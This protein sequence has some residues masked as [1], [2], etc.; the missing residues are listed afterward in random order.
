M[1]NPELTPLDQYTFARLDEILSDIQ[2]NP[3]ESPILFSLGEPQKPTPTILADT[4]EAHKT[5]WNRYPSPRGDS[6][7]REAAVNWLYRRYSLPNGFV[8]PERHVIPVPGTRQPLCQIGFICTPPE[9]NRK[10]PAILMPNPFYHVY[11]GAALVGRGEPIY[12]S[13]EHESD[14]LPVLGEISEEILTRTSIMF[15]CTPT[16]PQGTVATTKYLK[17]AIALAREYDFVLAV[18]ECYSEIYRDSPPPGG[19]EACSELGL[20]MENVVCFHSLSKRSSAPGLRSGFLVGDEK[21]VRKFSQFVTFGG[22]PLPVPIMH[23]STALWNDD[24]HVIENRAYYD[25]NFCIAEDIL[26]PHFDISTPPAGFFLWLK[27]GDG[28]EAS[29]KLWKKA[30]VK[31]VP[32]TLF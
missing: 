22:A 23:A 30:S 19:L 28:I 14:F 7:F 2:P 9:K 25:Q 32:G 12:L 26:R 21:I 5:L 11:Q 16:N 1:L 17:N 20:G 4:I 18:D 10:K 8:D 27:I 29:R 15:L 31:T 24:Q 6:A 13:A 3:Y